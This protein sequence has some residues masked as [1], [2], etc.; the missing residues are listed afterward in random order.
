MRGRAETRCVIIG[1]QA[2][3]Q[4]SVYHKCMASGEQII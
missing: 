2:M 4:I 3:D 1:V